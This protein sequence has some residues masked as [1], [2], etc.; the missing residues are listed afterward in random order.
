MHH[1]TYTRPRYRTLW[2]IIFT[3]IITLAGLFTLT[4]PGQ[5]ADQSELW[6][7]AQDRS[8]I[9]VVRD[10]ALVDTIKLPT[11]TNPHLLE[12]SPS[13][14]YAYIAGLGNG[15]L[16]I[17]RITDRVTKTLNVGTGGAHYAKATPDGT[18]VLLVQ[19]P[20]TTSSANR[21]IKVV[22]NEASET[23]TEGASLALP[24][25][26]DCVVFRPDGQ[27]AY[28]TL[29]DGIAV[30][31][32]ATMTL[33]KTLATSGRPACGFAAIPGIPAKFFVT[34]NGQ[35]GRLYTLDTGS[36]ILY[37]LEYTFNAFNL[38]VPAVSADG[39]KLYIT[40]RGDRGTEIRAEDV[41]YVVDLKCAVPACQTP[42]TITIDPRPG[43]G[44][45]MDGVVVQGNT[46]YIAFRAAGKLAM[47]DSGT[48]AVTYMDLV[49]PSSVALPHLT[50]RPSSGGQSV[51][52][53]VFLPFVAQ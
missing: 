35:G 26:A 8:E 15:N 27:R 20:T 30:V 39:T 41:L 36:D 31:D 45:R 3:T 52:E 33:V 11:G 32:V 2:L 40:D 17:M 10:Q 37:D 16:L 18:A 24:G 12:F 7:L 23:W 6:V 53:R 22:A 4:R 47:M 5:A 42:P 14:K 19:Q 25:V 28:V 49:P 1:T 46:V 51:L 21:V 43:T 34:S 29:R 50:V 38:H 13:G 48:Q 9:K 44:D